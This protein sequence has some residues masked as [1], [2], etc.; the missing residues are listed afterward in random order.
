M[1]YSYCDLL[2][3]SEPH[4]PPTSI[5]VEVDG[6]TQ[7]TI[8]WL[9]P[10]FED[11]NGPIVNYNIIVYDLTFG[12]DDIDVH[13]SSTSYTVTNLEEY[14]NYS[15]IVA[16]AT[17]AGVGPYSSTIKFTTQEDCE[18]GRDMATLFFIAL[19][20][21][22]A[23]SAPPQSISGDVRSSTLVVFTWSP[24]P[25][26]DQNGVI[27]YYVVKLHEVETGII[28][29][30]FAVDADINI[31]SLHPYYNYECTIAAYTIGAGPYS[32]AVSVQMEEAGWIVLL[33]LAQHTAVH[34][35]YHLQIVYAFVIS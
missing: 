5:T 17:V 28:W 2:C 14:S 6:S 25:S 7:A 24:P 35:I 27:R 11:Q 29:T 22:L 10:P 31:G 21:C 4:A 18:L 16:A 8:S 19:L 1:N 23:P 9:P 20:C 13:T 3:S 12:L 34:N 26:I 32:A 33:T 15:F 30:F